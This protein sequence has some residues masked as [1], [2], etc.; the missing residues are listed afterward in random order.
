MLYVSMS[1]QIMCNS[2]SFEEVREY[3]HEFGHISWKNSDTIVPILSIFQFTL[4]ELT[5]PND[6]S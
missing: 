4:P 6:N 1:N 2:L 5:I 3:I